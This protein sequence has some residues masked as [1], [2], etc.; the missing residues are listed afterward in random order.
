MIYKSCLGIIL[1]SKL[2]DTKMFIND[3]KETL[4]ED[5]NYS[6]T[7]NG[8]LGYRTTGKELLD[9]NFAISSMRNMSE[10]DITDKFEKVFYENKLYAIKWLFYARDIRGGI[11]E[12]RLFKICMRYL[13]NTHIKIAKTLL[14]LIAEYGRWDDLIDL[15]D[16]PIKDDVI[17][18]II[19]QLNQDII[20]M[21]NN[22][23]VSLLAKWIPSNNT[24]NRE[25][26]RTAN[27]LAKRFGI[28]PRQYRKMLVSLRSYLRVVEIDISKNN[29]DKID[30]S[31]VP[32][33]A[34]LLYK[35]AFMRHDKERRKE[36]LESLQRGE[37][38]INSS[39]LFPHDVVHKYME[40]HRG[41]L[42]HVK[43]QDDIALEEVWKGLPNYVSGAG[44][45]IVVADGSG[46]M[47]VRVD[48]K[49]SVSA[50]DV[51]NSLAIYFAERSSG[52]FKNNYIT[53]SSDPQL[54]D[55][56]NGKSLRE[57][58]AIALNYNEVADTNIEA[59]FA[60]ILQTAIN[61]NMKQDELPKNILILSDM[62]F[63]A[64]ARTNDGYGY[65]DKR[66]FSTIAEHYHVHGYQLPRLVFWNVNSRTGT[67]PIKENELGVALVSGFSPA[68]VRMVLSGQL[69]P[70]ECLIDQLNDERYQPVEEAVKNLVV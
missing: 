36:Y 62:E 29:W 47:T 43:S 14:P 56:S 59:V 19:E 3:L 26:V 64:C 27:M 50:L 20:H 23:P 34:N 44:N 2:E 49:S 9:M 61:K 24:S 54:V 5:F 8:A 55:L 13:A 30:Y 17:Y 57:K 48:N 68:I 10:Q 51:A 1:N 22:E 12:R 66:L 32:S 53:F 52:Q 46:S 28:S 7:E 38:K 37:T 70:Y 58:I 15:L 11:G 41:W 16:T 18:L 4:N 25:A 42:S 39:V 67:V 21:E 60:L 63:N 33:K 40:G 35:D 6:V 31:T 45:T 65:P 69:D